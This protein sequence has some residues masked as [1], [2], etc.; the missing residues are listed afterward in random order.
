MKLCAAKA[1]GHTSVSLATD[2][3]WL[4]RF[5]HDV[6]GLVAN[7]MACVSQDLVMTGPSSC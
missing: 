7:C 5:R 6:L 2:R 4:A 3:L 1:T